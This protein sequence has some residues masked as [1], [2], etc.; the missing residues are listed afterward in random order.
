MNTIS[1][2]IQDY[3]KNIP[4][5]SYLNSE[6]Q[7]EISQNIVVSYFEQG[8]YVFVENKYVN[9]LFYLVKEGAIGLFKNESQLVDE[10]DEGDILGLR[11][12]IRKDQYRL[13]A[14]ALEESILYAIPKELYETLISKNTKATQFVIKTFS[15]T[16]I[17][18]DDN[19]FNESAN[20]IP[21]EEEITANY[22]KNP[23]TCQEDT[24]IENAA[25]IMTVKKVGS[26]II[27]DKGKPMG[28]VTDKDLRTKIATGKF[29]IT[30]QISN[31]MSAPVVCCSC[32]VTIAEAQIAMLK[33]KITHLCITKDG[34][35]QTKI[36]GVLSEHDIVLIRQNNPSVLIKEIKRSSTIS[37]LRGIKKRSNDLLEKYLRQEVSIAFISR[38][39]S[40]IN[41]ALTAR[42]LEIAIQKMSKKPPVNFSWLS[43]GS[44]GRKEQVLITDQDNAI[45][46]ADEGDRLTK[47]YF[48]QLGKITTQYLS[49]I[50]FEYCP[51]NMMASNEQWCLSLS[52]W[53]AQFKKWIEQPSQENVMF[54]S[55]FFDFKSVFTDHQLA[56]ELNMF[57]I[58]AINKNR[59]FLQ[60]LGKNALLNPAP[61]SFFRQFLVEETGEHKDQ[62]DIKSRAMMPLVD[63]ARILCL[64]SGHTKRNTIERF[65]FLAK[66]EPQNKLTYENCIEAYKTFL[67]LRTRHGLR[68]H[69]SGRY[70]NLSELTKLERLNL[71]NSFKSIRE[72]QNLLMTRFQLA[73][74]M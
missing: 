74:L 70:I 14:K 25:H 60:H 12:I 4:P 47:D 65:K 63:A 6:D 52:E 32:E 30:D 41:N 20:S 35:D 21:L 22:S 49:E 39:I 34:T 53:K 31:I 28:I 17:G 68:H 48:L 71:K 36:Q 59:I 45:V 16:L 54:C 27:E 10:C 9:D 72:I 26:I 44:Q 11:A 51:A 42:S 58:D 1:L 61:L 23:I 50:G 24:S 13:S 8:D 3:L 18:T 56:S 38:M 57:I 37:E 64:E 43:L 15:S 5:F 19:Y 46:Y 29:S 67:E 55:I 40:E 69:D 33:N 2:R 73:Q 66:N 62:F 7:R